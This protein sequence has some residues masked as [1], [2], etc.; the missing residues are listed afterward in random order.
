MKCSFLCCVEISFVEL[1]SSLGRRNL[2][3]IDS[4]LLKNVFFFFEKIGLV[5][6]RINNFSSLRNIEKERVQLACLGNCSMNFGEEQGSKT[7]KIPPK[8]SR[9]IF[10]P[11]LQINPI[12]TPTKILNFAR[13][14]SKSNFNPHR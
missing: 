4:K 7:I 1:S 2:V 12:A 3:F 11:S 5:P 13:L 9:S 6:G 10:P 8:K 14:T